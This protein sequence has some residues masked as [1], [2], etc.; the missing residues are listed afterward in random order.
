MDTPALIDQL[1]RIVGPNG[2]LLGE[3]I[4]ERSAGIWRDDF[5]EAQLIVRPKNTQQ[6]ADILKLCHQHQQTVVIHGG[7]TG[8][9]AG[10]DS[11]RQDVVLSMEL[12][13]GIE[14]IDEAGRTMTVQAGAPLQA[15][16]EAAEQKG[17]LF[18]LDLGARGSC[19]IGGNVSTNAGGN[20]VIRYGMTRAQIL[21]LEV[22][23][24][25]GTIISSMNKMLKN[26]AGYDLKQLFVGTEGT[27]GVVTRVIIKLQTTP[28]SHSVALLGMQ[29]FND[30]IS[31]LNTIDGQLGGRLSAFE[32]LWHN[33]YQ[34]VTTEP[35]KAKPLLPDYPYYVLLDTLGADQQQD[36]RLFQNI[37][38]RALEKGLIC[39]A[40]IAESQQQRDSLWALRDDVE[41]VFRYGPAMIFDVSL[42]IVDM[43]RYVELVLN[44]WREY[45]PNG[46]FFTFGHLGDGNLHFVACVGEDNEEARNKIET[47][48]YKPLGP[49][50]GSISAEHGI[51]LEKKEFLSWCRNEEEIKLMKTLKQALDPS[52]ILNPGKIFDL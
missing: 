38:E 18:P 15:I 30:V 36:Q 4:N 22:V 45:F 6:V 43:E 2:I 21:G 37:L 39:D 12:M 32:V 9:V 34:L 47:A 10:A 42:A 44:R 24:A 8:L 27:L 41:Q 29:N 50:N 49:I 48:L 25:D 40:V 1:S 17:L 52:H 16:Q 13:N 19:T 5:V 14:E 7:L 3:E 46:H 11:T 33:F 23:L 28:T 51:G 31:L 26:N 35:A 20:R